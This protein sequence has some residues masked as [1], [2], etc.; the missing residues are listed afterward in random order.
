MIFVTALFLLASRIGRSTRAGGFAVLVYVRST[1]FY[2][3]N[4]QFSY[5]TVAIAMVM[6]TF[7]LLTRAFDSPL[8]RPGAHGHGCNCAS[9]RWPSPTT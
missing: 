7:Y 9:A 5:Q 8:E 4:A 3:F 2:F 6:A 1:Q